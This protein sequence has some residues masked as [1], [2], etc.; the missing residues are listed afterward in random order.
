MKLSGIKRHLRSYSIVQRRKTTINHAFAS[1]LAPCDAFDEGQLA[2]A[3]SL[4]GQAD[5]NALQCVYCN[6]PATSWDHLVG[7]VKDSQLS[8][9]G[10]QIGNLV[11][12]CRD[13]NSSKGNRDWRAFL[14]ETI[15]D[16]AERE[17]VEQ[18]LAKYLHTYAREIDL[19]RVQDEYPTEWQRD[20]EIK[21]EIINLMSEADRLAERLRLQVVA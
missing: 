3:M 11:P 17:K 6:S 18:T 7:L 4:L 12:S 5:F 21:A 20:N 16:V 19:R 10:H 8:G 1:A 15:A 9:Y 14:R 2:Q 13:C